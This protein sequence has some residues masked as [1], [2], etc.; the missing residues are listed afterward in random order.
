M[1]TQQEHQAVSLTGS[2]ENE[3]LQIA[4]FHSSL[5]E[6]DRKPGGVTMVVHRLA[7][8]LLKQG[9]HVTVFSLSPKPAGARYDHVHL[10][11]EYPWLDE[12]RLARLFL[13]PMLLNQVDFTGYDLLHT[14]GEDWFLFRRQLPTVRTLHGS[15]L[16]E[17]RSATS[18]KRQ[19]G[20]YVVYPLELL[21]QQL[22]TITQAVGPDTQRHYRTPYLANNG[23]DLD[24]FTPGP[25]TSR[26]SVLFVGSWEGRKRGDFLYNIFTEQVLNHVPDAILHMVCERRASH[27]N[28]I[29][30]ERPDDEKLSQLYRN[31]WVFAYPSVYEGFGLPYLEAMASG[32]AVLCSPNQGAKYVLED[33]AFGIIVPDQNFGSSLTKLLLNEGK[34][35]KWASKG[36]KRAQAFSWA[37]IASQ[38]RTLYREAIDVWRV[39]SFPN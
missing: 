9:D 34:R 3:R 32:T 12:N 15:A 38:H 20:Q 22:A 13:L 27:K 1:I 4:L 28:V 5:P 7:N 6:D 8:A 16:A 2:L 11:S 10:F 14:H 21:A 33:G 29:F 37:E 30:H 36:V 35:A 24:Q 17:A 23:V 31:A 26:P 25:K 18:L 39:N 19:I